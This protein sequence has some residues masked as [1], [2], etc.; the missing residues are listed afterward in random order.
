MIE[1][2]GSE[3]ADMVREMIIG[4]KIKDVALAEDESEILRV[5]M[6]REGLKVERQGL[7]QG[8]SIS[9]L[10]ATLSLA[11]VGPPPEG[12]IMYADDGMLVMAEE[13]QVSQSLKNES[14]F[15][16]LELIGA[17]REFEKSGFVKESFKFLGFTINL[18]DQTIE[19][20]GVIHSYREEDMEDLQRWVERFDLLYGKSKDLRSLKWD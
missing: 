5:E 13:D 2:E 18:T 20:E 9:P 6:S 17:K 11:T 1:V 3:L 4:L 15:N 19:R 16:Q 8:L 14:W 12:L 7:P 10:L